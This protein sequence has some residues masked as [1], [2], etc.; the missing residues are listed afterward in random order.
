MKW[1]DDT[2]IDIKQYN[3]ES[4]AEK[5][6]EDMFELNREQLLEYPQFIQTAYFI[7]DFDTELA[8]EG[9]Y[10]ILENSIRNFLPNIIKAFRS[11]GDEID[12]E[13]LSEILSLGAEEQLEEAGQRQISRLSNNL[14]LYTDRD[15]WKKLFAYLDTEIQRY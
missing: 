7:I 2:E 10:G 3:G 6:V 12:A 1:F 5:I 4:L 13:L 15:V 8:M 11:I 14:Y 9:I